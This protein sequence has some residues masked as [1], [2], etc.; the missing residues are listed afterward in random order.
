MIKMEATDK[1]NMSVHKYC[2]YDIFVIG[3]LGEMGQGNGD[4]RVSTLSVQVL[5]E[6]GKAHNQWV[7]SVS[8]NQ[9]CK[10]I[11][12]LTSLTNR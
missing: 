1:E 9:C 5:A 4:S 7:I 8:I 3:K 12:N 11:N 6:V 2:I 10:K